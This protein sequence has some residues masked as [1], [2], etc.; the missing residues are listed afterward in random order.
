[1]KEKVLGGYKLEGVLEEKGVLLM[2]RVKTRNVGQSKKKQTKSGKW[3]REPK[4]L[5]SSSNFW[6]THLKNIL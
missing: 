5:I 4:M 6:K 1:M 3:Q 2:R